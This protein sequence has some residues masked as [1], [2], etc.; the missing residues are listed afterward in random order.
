[1]DLLASGRTAAQPA[2]CQLAAIVAVIVATALG[3]GPSIA[4]D[5]ADPDPAAYDTEPAELAALR[6]LGLAR[7]D[8]SEQRLEPAR[9]ALELLIARYP[10]SAS[11][12]TARR[13]LFQLYGADTQI[14][15]AVL[16]R[17]AAV[18][19]P[20]PAGANLP[21][22]EAVSGWRTSVVSIRRLQDDFRNSLGDRIFFSA[23]SAELGSRARA[24]LA[25]QAAWLASRPQVE[26][27]VE[28][29]AD[30]A[31]TGAD[32]EAV[33]ASRARAVRDRLIE[34]GVE[35]GRIALTSKGGS[36]PVATC[37]NSDCAAQNRRA[38][39]AVGV[40]R[41]ENGLGPDRFSGGRAPAP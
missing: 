9:R 29:H 17:P 30:D 20:A 41:F 26:V 24:V 22:P 21:S 6:L 33:A 2:G 36:D 27:S 31:M 13:E 4:R 39:I 15:G 8:R 3:V 5:R 25:A 40:R 19:S 7:Q 12:A 1:M 14:A 10:D 38:V 11:A 37:S 32:N 18:P 35:P 16:Q 28:G 23:G 34:E